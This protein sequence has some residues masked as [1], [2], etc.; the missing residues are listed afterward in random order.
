MTSRFLPSLSNSIGTFQ[1]ATGGGSYMRE[2]LLEA[3]ELEGYNVVRYAAGHGPDM[4]ETVRGPMI[5][6]TLRNMDTLDE[7]LTSSSLLIL[8]GSYTPMM[9]WAAARASVLRQGK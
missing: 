8:S 4:V 5:N 1:G 6:L 2:V 7:I 9:A 3:L